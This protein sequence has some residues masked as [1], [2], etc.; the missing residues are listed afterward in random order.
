MLWS[1]P[2][3]VWQKF[4]LTASLF[5]PLY[6]KHERDAKEKCCTEDR[7][8]RDPYSVAADEIG[9]YNGLKLIASNYIKRQLCT[10]RGLHNL[11][12]HNLNALAPG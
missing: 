12:S 10:R 1:T 9:H 6:A 2:C 4:N 7:G 11:S 5:L 3:E 8:I